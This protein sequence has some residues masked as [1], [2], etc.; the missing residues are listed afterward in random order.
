MSFVLDCLSS[1][2]ELEE[3]EAS[4]LYMCSNCK[5]KQRSTKKFWIRRLPNVS[6][7][8]KILFYTKM[9]RWFIGLLVLDLAGV[10][11]LLFVKTLCDDE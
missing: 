6:I 2:T 8:I 11:F 10:G 5:K 4:E 3:L 7:P 1:F 9:L